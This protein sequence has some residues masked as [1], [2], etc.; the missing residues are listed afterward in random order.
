MGWFSRKPYVPTGRVGLF[1]APLTGTGWF[2]K[3]DHFEAQVLV[4]ET[5]KFGTNSRVKVLEVNGISN[6]YRRAVYELVDGMFLASGLI[7]WKD[8]NA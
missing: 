7:A 4:E 2:N 6:D 8:E 1:T 5:E 3:G